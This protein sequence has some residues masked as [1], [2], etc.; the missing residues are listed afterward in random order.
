MSATK[1]KSPISRSTFGGS[2]RGLD[3]SPCSSVE[4]QPER[5][6]SSAVRVDEEAIQTTTAEGFGHGLLSSGFAVPGTA[7][8]Q[9]HRRRGQAA[10][11]RFTKSTML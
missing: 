10:H 9:P 2:A 1:A 4:I 3:G 5:R 7:S 8:P 6:G 11:L